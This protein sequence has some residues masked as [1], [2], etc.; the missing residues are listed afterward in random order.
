MSQTTTRTKKPGILLSLKKAL[1]IIPISPEEELQLQQAKLEEATKKQRK[2]EDKLKQ[3][4]RKLDDARRKSGLKDTEA[5]AHYDRLEKAAKEAE[6]RLLGLRGAVTHMKL[7]GQGRQT[8]K[9][10]ADKKEFDKAKSTMET[11][12]APRLLEQGLAAEQTAQKK[13]QERFPAVLK[14]AKELTNTLGGLPISKDEVARI[15]GDIESLV[16]PLSGKGVDEDIVDTVQER[17]NHQKEQVGWIRNEGELQ[18]K[19]YLDALAVASPAVKELANLIGDRELSPLIRNLDMAKQWAQQKEFKRAA[20]LAETV[21]TDAKQAHDTGIQAMM[22]W[23]DRETDVAPLINRAKD[24][25]ANDS[26]VLVGRSPTA[27]DILTRLTTLQEYLEADSQ[28][29]KQDGASGKQ[30]KPTSM[31]V[32]SQVSYAE[33]VKITDEAEAQLDAL[34]DLLNSANQMQGD[35]DKALSAIGGKIQE[36]R[37]ALGVMRTAIADTVGKEHAKESDGLFGDQLEAIRIGWEKSSARAATPQE[38]DA[39]GTGDKLDKLKQ[40]I[41]TVASN[42]AK[43]FAVYRDQLFDTARQSFDAADKLFATALA[44]L[45]MVSATDAMRYQAQRDKC[46]GA[47]AKADRPSTINAQTETLGTIT[48]KVN[49]IGNLLDKNIDKQRKAAETLLGEVKTQIDG[50]ETDINKVRE[51]Q[52]HNPV[53]NDAV[54]YTPQ[55]EALRDQYEQLDAVVPVADMGGLNDAVADL[56]ILLIGAKAARAALKGGRDSSGNSIVTLAQLGKDLAELSGKLNRKDFRSYIAVTQA[57]LINKAGDL[58][59]KLPTMM[60]PAASVKL[61]ELETAYEDAKKLMEKTKGGVEEFDKSVAT[62]RKMLKDDKALFTNAPEAYASFDSRIKSCSDAARV[63]GELETARKKMLDILVELQDAVKDPQKIEAAQTDASNAKNKAEENAARFNGQQAS[64]LKRLEG[65]T[66]LQ[67]KDRADLKKMAEDSKKLF[68][69]SGDYDSAMIQLGAASQRAD[70]LHKYPEGAATHARNNLPKVV[71]RWKTA[72]NAFGQS[73]KKLQEE[74]AKVQDKD[75]YKPAKAAAEKM[76]AQIIPMFNPTAFDPAVAKMT[77]RNAADNVLTAAREEGLRFVRRYN[78][79]I[80]KDYRFMEL[81]GNPFL[82]DVKSDI[83]ACHL[84]LCDVE[85]NLLISV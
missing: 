43:H 22:T 59:D 49:E 32:G 13:A 74:I 68:D 45:I 44:K 75:E 39:K 9:A 62:G 58:S 25:A 78:A 33:A 69:R 16:A 35:R 71:E 5:E 60:I 46:A 48:D 1:K 3:K 84:A 83:V 79:Y 11:L 6:D 24:L 56:G 54:A 18:R 80:D 55:F 27:A 64:F 10:F 57:S 63:E 51:D 65:Y 81:S 72:A 36:V 66:E 73:L 85:R 38:L 20:D 23:D 4:Q 50:F 28:K 37:Q 15:T 19:R 7:I 47:A 2:E 21:Q 14:F 40:D 8:A 82:P 52:K 42:P 67:D 41:E 30:T 76:I 12:N 70:L 61:E 34:D 26:P 77:A 29:K 31:M 53:K 17:L